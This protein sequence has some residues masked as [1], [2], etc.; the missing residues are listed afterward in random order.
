MDNDL[1]PRMVA[2]LLASIL[3]VLALGYYLLQDP[4]TDEQ[5]ANCVPVYLDGT[6][7]CEY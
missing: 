5:K 3:V 2:F 1:T 6:N 7:L 4:R